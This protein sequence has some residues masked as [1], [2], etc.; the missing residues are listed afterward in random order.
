[1]RS[2]LS[3]RVSVDPFSCT[4]HTTIHRLISL[5][6][7]L[8][9]LVLP[10]RIVTMP[11]SRTERSQ[12]VRTRNRPP[13]KCA[14]AN[15]SLTN[16]GYRLQDYHTAKQH[17]AADKFDRGLRAGLLFTIDAEDPA[18]ARALEDDRPS[19]LGGAWPPDGELD[20][21]GCYGIGVDGWDGMED[22]Q[23]VGPCSSGDRVVIGDDRQGSS[24]TP[25]SRTPSSRPPSP[26]PPSPSY[27][28]TDESNTP[29]P[30]DDLHLWD[31]EDEGDT[32]LVPAANQ[33]Q[34]DDVVDLSTDPLHVA[35]DDLILQTEPQID[36]SDEQDELPS[37]FRDDPAIRHAYIR[38]W[39]LA[40]FKGATHDAVQAVLEGQKT[41]MEGL[42]RRNPGM[43][44]EGLGSM[45]RT[46]A[47]AERRLG[48]STSN[49]ITY[50]ML[51]TECWT[52]HDSS[53]L[54]D[55]EL[56]DCSQETCHGTIYKEKTLSGG[57]TKR[58]PL[59]I[60]P[61]VSP[62]RALQHLLLRPG[63]YNQ[64]QHWR[65]EGD[66]SDKP[67]PALSSTGYDAFDDH[68][69]PM[70]DI[71]DGWKWRHA[72][73]GLERR[74]GGIWG[75]QDVDVDELNQRFVGLPCGLQLQMNLDWYVKS[76]SLHYR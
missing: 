39:V 7:P 75:V 48:L 45:A 40:T 59:K 20:D 60:L 73:A 14:C 62:E 37:A 74:R 63:K 17:E 18:L 11:A 68:D 65:R 76:H 61:Y 47:T 26:R 38:A 36:D 52:M 64:F 50:Y 8:I 13:V 31:S 41:S 71:S 2:S 1:M 28:L 10:S 21:D 72:R 34:E 54:L 27:S 3:I 35:L 58:I 25:S 16:Q 44:I 30:F 43:R 55:L 15:C 67:T 22:A 12:A 56:P 49:Y 66:E 42:Q 9:H 57:R 46:L 51:C 70:T 33:D 53:T 69:R 4:S 24:R 29:L 23:R 6:A 19:D 5:L 32:S